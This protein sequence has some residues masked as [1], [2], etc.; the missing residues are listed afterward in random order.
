VFRER[1]VIVTG[2]AQGIGYAVAEGF[3]MEN[4]S[5]IAVDVNEEN[6]K[7]AV[8]DW[9]ARGLKVEFYR[10]DV[11]H[12]EQVAQMMNEI[13]MKFGKIDILINNAGVS[14]FTNIWEVTE[15]EWNKVL[16]TNLSSVF[17]CSREA[18]KYM[19]DSGGAIVNLSST[20]A[21]M[22]EAHTEAYSATKG[23]I[24]S[25]THALAIT[26]GEYGIRVN[27][28]SPGWV[29]TTH[30]EA[31]REIDH[32]QHPAGRVGRPR[33]I[34]KACFYLCDPENSFVTGENITVDGGMTKK[35][36]YEP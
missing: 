28:I 30:D 9:R 6:G 12:S 4:A 7:R 27:S 11:G 36:I 21:F 1:V 14:R 19:K 24:Y 2:A 10:C 8:E 15:Q 25:L 17:F 13:A 3:A 20:R 18:A 16:S 23:G 29:E 35:M 31:L 32:Q 22:S 5:V 34:V 33:D 26:L